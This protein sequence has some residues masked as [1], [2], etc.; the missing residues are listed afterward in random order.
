[1]AHPVLF[2]VRPVII[3]A[4]KDSIAYVGGKMTL[5]C[6][7]DGYPAPS[8]TW[9]QNGIP[10]PTTFVHDISRDGTELTF[11]N[12]TLEDAGTYRCFA[13]NSAGTAGASAV[14]TVRDGTSN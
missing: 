5:R 7:A 9:V 10:T 11:L 13:Q 4:P 3:E 14:L 8:L 12:V 2:S 6:R 1:M